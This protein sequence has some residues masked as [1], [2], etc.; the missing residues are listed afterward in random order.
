MLQPIQRFF[1]FLQNALTGFFA[2]YGE[3]V[4]DSQRVVSPPFSLVKLISRFVM[5]ASKMLVRHVDNVRSVLMLGSIGSGQ[6][7]EI[8]PTEKLIKKERTTLVSSMAPKFVKMSA[9]FLAGFI[10]LFLFAPGS[11][12][13]ANKYW[14]GGNGDNVGT[15]ANDWST[16]DPAACADGLGDAAAVPG[17]SDV[18]IFD[19]DC[20]NNAT[21][22]AAWSVAGLTINTGYIGTLTQNTTNTL[23]VGS[24]NYSQADG[25]FTGGS[26]SITI[27]GTYTLSGGTF[28]STSGTLTVTLATTS[29]TYGTFFT[30]SGGT[31]T[32]NSGTVVFNPDK[33]CCGGSN[34]TF[35]ADVTSL[36]LYNVEVNASAD[37]D[38]STTRLNL[39]AGDSIAVNGNLTITD[40]ALESGTWN[41]AGNLIVGA[42]AD[43]YTTGQS[44]IINFNGSG[45]QTYTYSAGGSS[46]AIVINKSTGTVS[47]AGGTTALTIAKFTL[48]A[49]SFTA[50]SGNL[51]INDARQSGGATVFS[52]VSGTTFTHNSGT[53]VFSNGKNCCGGGATDTIDVSGAAA[54]ITFNNV[55]VN[56]NNDSASINTLSVSSGDSVIA[57]GTL[58]LTNGKITGAWEGQGA[59]S[60][61]TGFDGGS[62]TL[63]F[64]GTANQTYTDSGGDEP[65]GDITINKSSG[66][67]T[68]A[69][70]AD[71]N[72]TSQDV[73]VT[74]GT[75]SLA[76][77]TI[78][79]AV[80]TVSSGA[81]LTLQ[82]GETVT[83]TTKTFS[84][85]STVSYTGTGSYTTALAAGNTYHHLTFN[86]SGGVWEPDG[87]VTVAG[88]LTITAG[89]FDIDGQNLTV[90]GTFANSGTLRLTGGE[91]T[92]S[93]TMDVDTGTI[94][95]DGGTS[96]SGLKAGNSYFNLTFAGT[97]GT[98]SA[99][100]AET[101]A[102]ALVVS[103]GTYNANAQT[104][105]VTGT[106]TISGGT[107]QSSTATQ[108]FTGLV[109]ISSGT[110]TASSGT[111][112]FNGGLTVSGGTYTG[113][114]GTADVNG[115]F[116]LSSG[117]LTA[118]SGTMFVSGTFNRSAGTFTHNSG[119][120]VLDNTA[121]KTLTN[122]QAF[123]NLTIN[124][125]LLGYW[126]LDETAANGCTG[127]SN[128]SCDSSGYGNDGAWNG[129]A[130]ASATVPTVN[131]TN[132]RSATFD[133]TGDYVS[134]SH[135]SAYAF[136]S[137]SYT[138]SAWVKFDTTDGSNDDVIVGKTAHA[139]SQTGYYL[140][141][142]SGTTTVDFGF[143]DGAAY[144][145]AAGATAIGTTNWAQVVGVFDDSANTLT[146]YVN[147]TSDGS[148]ASVTG[149]PQSNSDAL[150]I[151]AHTGVAGKALDGLIDDVR[152]YGRALSSTEVAR[153]GAGNQPQT[154]SATTTLGG[155][156]DIDSNLTLNAG[157]LDTASGSNYGI[158]VAGSWLNN[159]GVFTS[160]SGTVTLDG[161]ATGKSLLSGSQAFYN[162]TLNGSGGA[163]TL[164]DALDV[165]NNATITAGTLDANSTSN[166]GITVGNNW[167]NSG[168][169]TARSGTVTLDGVNQTISGATTFYNLTKNDGTDDATN[170]TLTFP[171]STTTTVPGTFTANG[172]DSTDKV[173]L[174]SS[175]PGTQWSI[176]PT[177]VSTTYS[178]VTDSNNT[179]GSVINEYAD[180]NVTDGGNNTNWA[181]SSNSAFTWM[182]TTSSTWSTAANWTGGVAPGTS[183]TA[184]F[185][186]VSTANATISSTVSVA[187]V[188]I[189]SAYSGTITQSTTNTLTV[190]SSNYSQA[191]GTFTGGSGAVTVN[192]TYTLS[193][194][195][196]TSTSGTMT[197]TLATTS[198][199]YG[200]FFTQSGGTFTHNSGTVAFN[201]DKTCCGGSN[202]TFTVDVNSSLSLY[203]VEI[204]ASADSDGSTTRLNLGASDSITVNGNLTLTDGALES[205]TW[206]LVGNL[207]V[208]SSADFYSNSS[209]VVKF[210]GSGDQTYAFTSG[211]N[212]SNITIDKSTGT[213]TPAVGTTALAVGAFTLTA[214]SFTAPSGTMTIAFSSTDSSETVFTYTAGTFTHNSGTLA[215]TG[216]KACCGGGGT[217]TVSLASGLTVGSVSVNL[218]NDSGSANTLAIATSTL[219]VSSGLTLTNGAMTGTIAVQGDLSVGSGFDGGSATLTFSGTANQTY[220]DSGGN[221]PDG[222]VT[223]NKSSGTV[224]LA[225]AADWNATSQDV[226]VTS[227]T[228]SLASY[229]ISTAV[230]TVS[231]GAFLQLQGG[232]TVTATTK[233]FSSGSTVTY[234]GTSS[235]TTA[236]AAGN[237]Y[238]HLTFNGSG[239]VWEPDG[240]VTVAGNLTITAGTFDIDG[241]NLT[242][243]GTY[244]NADTL[245]L[246][247]GETTFSVTNDTDSGT[248][249]YDGTGT[250]SSL[251]AGNSYYHVT[252]NGTGGSWTAAA[253][254]DVNGNFTI[255]DGTFVAPSTQ[256]Y[257]GGAFTRSGGTFTH[258]SGT[259]QLDST[260]N[261]TLTNTQAFNNLNIN[262]GLVGYWKL[263]ETTTTSG[264]TVV[265]SSGH[266]NTGTPA[267][268][269]GTN[270]LPQPS[271]SVA[272]GFDFTNG[273]SLDFD[274]TDDYVTSA[275]NI[276][277]TGASARTVSAWIKVTSFGS[278][279]SPILYWGSGN[280]N[281]L[282]LLGINTSRQF[283]FFGYA[284]DLTGSTILSTAT[285]YHV[286][287]TYDG[288]NRKIY[289]NGTQD[290]SD[291]T[292][293]L[294]T[295]ASAL[296]IG[297]YSLSGGWNA[298]FNGNIDD[299]R[300][301]NRALSS[302]EISALA[303]GNASATAVTTTLGGALDVNGDLTVA[304]NTLDTASGSNYGINLAGNWNIPLGGTFTPRSGTVTLDGTS[305]GKTIRSSSN[306]FNNL[307][308]NGT[309]G[310]W[311][312][313]DAL[314]INASAT[315]SAGTLDASTSNYGITVANSW[316]DS[317]NN[318]TERSGTVTFDG[319]S[320]STITNGGS[321]YNMTLNGSGTW[322][323][324]ANLTASNACTI[325]AGTL[326]M[327]GYN[328]S[329]TSF[330]NSGTLRLL[331]TES[332]V[333][334]PSNLTTAGTVAYDNTAT[335]SSFLLGN[336]Y[337]NLTLGGSGTVALAAALD[338]NNN[339]TVSS[340]ATLNHNGYDITFGG[341]LSNSGTISN[342]TA[343]T[344]T[345]DGTTQTFT[346]SNMT[347]GTLAIT[348]SSGTV[349]AGSNFTLGDLL[350]I[351]AG[352]VFSLLSFTVTSNGSITNLGTIT[353]SGPGY[354]IDMA[355]SFYIADSS[356][357]IDDAI[358]LG[359]DKVYISLTDEDSNKDGT[360]ADTLTGTVVS[361]ATDS[362][363]VTLTET[364]AATEV[365]RNSGGLTTQAYDGSATNNDGTLECNDTATITA[366]FTDPQ[367]SSDTETDTSTATGDTIPTAPSSF[368]GSAPSSTSITW[369]WTDN[370][371][372]EDGFKLYNSSNTLIATIATANTTSYTETSLTKGTSYTRKLVSYND[373]G[374]SS[375]SGSASVTTP[376][377][378]TAPSAF[379]GTAASSTSITWSWTD[380]SN[381]ET[382]W[383]LQD[384]G[385]TTVATITSTTGSATGGTISYTETGL[386]KGTS[387]TRK[388]AASNSDGTSTAT[389]TATVTTS[390]SA[391]DS[392]SL[393]SPAASA[394]LTTNLPTFS[395][396]KSADTDDGIAS[397][398]LTV[399]SLTFTINASGPT[400]SSD[401]FTAQY[402]NE[403][404]GNPSNDTISVT[405]K[406]GN[407]S[408]L[409][410]ADGE[411]SW[412]VTATDNGGN[413]RVTS[414][415]G[416]TVD[417]SSPSIATVSVS[418][419]TSGPYDLT[420]TDTSPTL[421]IKTSDSLGL[422]DMVVTLEEGKTIL[423]V[424][425]G[426]TTK[427]TTT[428]TLTGTSQTTTHTPKTALTAGTTYRVTIKTTD[429]AG[430]TTTKQY[431]LGVL[432]AAQQAA[433]EVAELD[434]DTAETADII[435]KLRN[436]QPE[437]PFSI[438]ELTAQAVL[439]RERQAEIFSS[440]LAQW[441]DLLYRWSNS[442]TSL[443]HFVAWALR[444]GGSFTDQM[445]Y[446]A[447]VIRG[448]SQGVVRAVA[449][450]FEQAGGNL[451]RLAQGLGQ[452]TADL[453]AGVFTG[454]NDGAVR[455]AQ[456]VG[457]SLPQLPVLSTN[458]LAD[459]AKAR[460]QAVADGTG[461]SVNA[462]SFFWQKGQ[463]TRVRTGLS[464]RQVIGKQILT[465]WNTVSGRVNNL[466]LR[467][468]AIAEIAL[469][470]EP[471]K[472]SNLKI[473]ALTPTSAVI[474]WDTNHLTRLGKVNYGTFANQAYDKEAF[475]A[476]GLRD[477]H[478]V[479]LTGL[480]PATTYYFE[481][482][483]QNGGYVFDAYYA[484]TTPA[485]E[486]VFNQELVPQ[487]AV[488]AVEEVSV[489]AEPDPAAQVVTTVKK[490]ETY[491]ALLVQG[492]WVSILLPTRAQGWV[493]AEQ[494][495]LHDEVREVEAQH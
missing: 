255:T 150:T 400:Q 224:T 412:K 351:A 354:I 430:N 65:D 385:G 190:G 242:V 61:G 360:A 308:I 347:L 53:V 432:T 66:T 265:D 194:G 327:S 99:G 237:T 204:N 123:N 14:V 199:T 72:A 336:T 76:S 192:G 91:T 241:Q 101:V 160:R 116:T 363:T 453:L 114:S 201:P 270:N 170:R 12:Q 293:T 226:T 314:D 326:D 487:V 294:N 157:T 112:T 28:T 16:T 55:T 320:S 276:P 460:A 330:T 52:M 435:E 424:L 77:Y 423:G 419:S 254:T 491:R 275:N 328:L 408:T 480:D 219:T 172:T 442:D 377:E 18:A 301:Y 486:G 378:P 297:E 83:A 234:V 415:R 389:S 6:K 482:M 310:V 332:A 63:S 381:D 488:I 59:V 271:A 323:A 407:S 355:T 342:A 434:A 161:T 387:Y 189:T 139:T 124:D 221:E 259:V 329:C 100:A 286:A 159:G 447:S 470:S 64:T 131:F 104:T 135:N 398:T 212:A 253:A 84:S 401:L 473:A 466:A 125:G 15:N 404:D 183:D 334:S 222:D 304:N 82:G 472:I 365:F 468:R 147:G 50:P 315:I 428:Y 268:A 338:V 10:F 256:L 58:T 458:T 213:I 457:L 22:A 175:S 166:W 218:L 371:S 399:D 33:T 382:S 129:D 132:P 41:L 444:V 405:L 173:L 391:P 206:N 130:T 317:G 368:A 128:D 118:P 25:T 216:G 352:R 439:R 248:T 290:G 420:S 313:A 309:G 361:C 142:R 145:T 209:G 163:W 356:F 233:T 133:G 95:Y 343:R 331:G 154:T 184:V 69:S 174:V 228:L 280:S 144:K 279:N 193:G 302:T 126:K 349:S 32:H 4:S 62:A 278:N 167:S 376:A 277:I 148:A 406:A 410:L 42:S 49:G 39:G 207:I 478:R 414:T 413:T 490:G 17:A 37:S 425:T 272:S 109:T 263:D 465:V 333:T 289:V 115:D 247:G 152:I 180:S 73:T 469:D 146:V 441:G 239:G 456:Q 373:A 344:Y 235:Y 30:Q 374:N 392:F 54:S 98:W 375:Y 437:Q 283:G 88:N 484:L 397:Y 380:N 319:S 353:E 409:P 396:Q 208:G 31:F 5:V 307:T 479:E 44:G 467:A 158:T 422:D 78:A 200:T 372:N 305:S 164:S 411:H 249:V 251:K 261:Q 67:V 273:R 105:A 229:N 291:T 110:F 358:S 45:D 122:T 92:F 287:A 27:N 197:V 481:V 134:V 120:V 449:L 364:G 494:V 205:G 181:F 445:Q 89:T 426:Y 11:A 80:L 79:T 318:F 85:G 153:L 94:E 236:L 81:T 168:T 9:G 285:W 220:T 8:F 462:L 70:N 13:A 169:F 475:E 40:G 111:Q 186:G 421:T 274:G 191:G 149:N 250:Y 459:S 292:S 56:L 227:G 448:Y 24:S 455:L 36:S 312:L 464:N 215:F 19:A 350:S 138:I 493:R 393:L 137:G 417:T 483:N 429:D 23:T 107:Y 474:E 244:S 29:S 288:T 177:T 165:D 348:G 38:G 46:A 97:G 210:N 306:S 322:D 463:D 431:T 217:H 187:G 232:E 223:I 485:Q 119:T 454:L 102:G 438:P 47:A 450:F 337:Y 477:H 260:S 60:I 90:T 188:S 298:G 103:A 357:D 340:G 384:S 198:S 443:G 359:V 178:T 416:F 182:G 121:A 171:A 367:D 185:S 362:E 379:S 325:T 231:S 211:G 383:V 155:A 282:S 369:T 471:T 489:L 196:F 418:S 176:N 299:V 106:T 34:A 395:F 402:F 324:A 96:Y 136:T 266:S 51:T 436:L 240:A 68:L 71:W 440:L 461:R 156:L 230:L 452:G 238:H 295:S 43:I 21:I 370:S 225:S 262:D 403:N 316:A 257:V 214:G 281:L 243:T 476:D 117:T 284:N 195:T 321:F 86:G 433:Q 303:A 245:R 151:G 113:S 492:E 427:E 57:A 264:A 300:I 202:A 386:T 451:V 246:T 108:T 179:N 388:M 311:T 341:T 20:D 162:L 48:T 339:L 446:L 366:T 2:I 346:P 3:V 35:T 127:G 345:A 394:V 93:V 7:L 495:S 1:T 267:G 143:Y 296:R 141:Q 203:N 87:A 75:L 390:S 74:S 26:G 140:V 252:F 269:S 258:N 335:V